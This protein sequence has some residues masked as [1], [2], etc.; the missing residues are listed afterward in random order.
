MTKRRLALLVSTSA[1]L[2]VSLFPPVRSSV[3]SAYEQIKL[4]VDVLQYIKEQYVEEAN[5]KTLIYG[6]AAG[7][8]RTLDPFSQFM[9]PEAHKEMK[10]ET[11]GE[12]GG[13]GI[14]I[15]V[16]DGWLVV[17]T[18]LPETP[19]YRLGIL[20]GDK[21]VR[22]EGE[23]TQGITVMD[24]V[25][26]LRGK[27]KTK[28]T[29]TILR[30][31]VPD[32]KDYVVTRE[33]IKIESVKYEMK[34]DGIGYLRLA[35]FIEPSVMDISK[36][37]KE[38]KA[39]G[40][41]S[42][43]FDLRNNPGGLLTS[44]VDVSKLFLGGNKLIVYTQGRSS[45]RQDFRADSTAPFSDL[46]LVLLV[47]HGSASASEIVS[48]AVQDHRRGLIIGSQTFGKGSVQ[49]IIAL[50]DASALRLTTAKYYTPLGRSIH[51]DEK[52][53]TGGITPDIM[54]EIPKEM[55]A[56]LYAQAE[57]VYAKDKSPQ[58]AVKQEEQVKDE[59]LSHA[60]EVLK[61]RAL[62]EGVKKG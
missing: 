11:E 1:F 45:P 57:E 12:F 36:A 35:E 22:I 48:G 25:K 53:K 52:S 38:L 44:A 14:R 42:L 10:T 26:K 28:V 31:G 5:T 51:R 9:E 37:L 41:T 19:A 60:I 29:I 24:A 2:V 3:N 58:S 34:S 20:P 23:S 43:V 6:A 32:P 54:I 33:I 59:A 7:M 18:P 13:L 15:A 17:M 4:V 61:A 56:K 8:V 47:N 40:M 49:S 21:I 27:P 50:D 55:E 62:F 46:P 30:E 16:R 39:K